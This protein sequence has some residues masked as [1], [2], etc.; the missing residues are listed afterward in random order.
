MA[1]TITTT[2]LWGAHLHA[3]TFFTAMASLEWSN[4]DRGGIDGGS[5][6][7]VAISSSQ[8][9]SP[10]QVGREDGAAVSG[11]SLTA[12]MKPVGSIV[13]MHECLKM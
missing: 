12:I 9:S 11:L 10:S 7:G 13:H 2:D 4:S 5:G 6:G 8:D 1:C 3:C